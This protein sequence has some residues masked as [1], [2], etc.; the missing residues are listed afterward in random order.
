MGHSFRN[1]Q[2]L[3]CLRPI[4][5]GEI[6]WGIILCYWGDDPGV[7]DECTPEWRPITCAT[8]NFMR[9]ISCSAG[10]ELSSRNPLHRTPAPGIPCRRPM[11]EI[12]LQ[13]VGRF[14]NWVWA[15]VD[16]WAVSDVKL[17]AVQEFA[18]LFRTAI[19]PG[20]PAP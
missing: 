13:I 9:S 20:E 1:P 15:G 3:R 17:D 10:T 4:W 2:K 18:H 8:H 14:A 5:Q 12:K 16:C 6:K 11:S 19:E 7:D